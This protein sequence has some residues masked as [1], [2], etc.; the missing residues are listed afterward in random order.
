MLIQG[1]NTIVIHSH[2]VVSFE[3]REMI[4]VPE[5][6]PRKKKEKNSG[7]NEMKLPK[8]LPTLILYLD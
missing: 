3:K 6:Q 7:M 2:D 5:M 8:N 4:L 1:A